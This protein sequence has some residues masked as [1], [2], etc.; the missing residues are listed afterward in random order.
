M[1]HYN[2]MNMYAALFVDRF[3][4][5]GAYTKQWWNSSGWWSSIKQ[6]NRQQRKTSPGT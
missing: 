3:Q 5:N 6:A 1:H 4:Q 2:D